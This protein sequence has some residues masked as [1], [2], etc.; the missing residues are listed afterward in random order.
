MEIV[1][2]IA[3]VF[4]I[5][6]FLCIV[7]VLFLFIR[8]W[9]Y[10]KNNSEYKSS[11]K[12]IAIVLA[13]NYL[14]EKI[15]SY[16]LDVPKLIKY[17]KEKHWPYKV[18]SGIDKNEL[19]RIINN[20]N[21]A[22]LYLIG[23]GRRHGIRVSRNEAVDYCEFH[24]APRKK[25]IAQCHCNQWGG[26]SLAECMSKRPEKSYIT[27]KKMGDAEINKLIDNVV[28]GKVHSKP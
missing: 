26:K 18:Y 19:K 9:L 13:N 8:N 20:P 5:M 24:N 27:R 7:W 1:V 14:P 10:V 11:K 6:T 3:L 21:A 12:H 22:I 16:A 25:F 17:F 15:L 4:M 28:K 2:I 23:H